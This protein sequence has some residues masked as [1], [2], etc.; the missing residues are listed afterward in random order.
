MTDAYHDHSNDPAP[1]E[2]HAQVASPKALGLTLIFMVLGVLAVIFILVA[3]FDNFMSNYRQE[4]N[5]TSA[6]SAPTW[7]EKQ[8]K[9]AELDTY[10]WVDA[11]TAS[12]PI[13]QA[14]EEVIAEYASN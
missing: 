8:A 4:V 11:Q 3:Y 14:M 6:L 2:A 1:Q 12:Q 10:R 5:E 13:D 7:E 9:L